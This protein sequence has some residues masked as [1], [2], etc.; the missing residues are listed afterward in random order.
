MAFNSIK[1][2]WSVNFGGG[3]QKIIDVLTRKKYD[4]AKAESFFGKFSDFDL[5]KAK[6]LLDMLYSG[7]DFDKLYDS[8]YELLREY[9]QTLKIYEVVCLTDPQPIS[10]SEDKISYLKK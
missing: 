7:Y 4:E 6:D 9:L 3:E 1:I 10:C 2:T 5:E 8:R